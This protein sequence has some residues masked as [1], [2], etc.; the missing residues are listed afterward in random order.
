MKETVDDDASKCKV[1][2]F[3]GDLCYTDE[4]G[5][6]Y[7]CWIFEELVLSVYN[8]Y[9]VYGEWGLLNLGGYGCFYLFVFMKDTFQNW[10]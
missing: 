2:V 5:L 7:F 4:D 6:F 3:N 9:I 10:K 1:H 8:L